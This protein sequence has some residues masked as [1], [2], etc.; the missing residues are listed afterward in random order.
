MSLEISSPGEIHSLLDYV[1][2]LFFNLED[3]KR[4]QESTR[5]FEF[6]EDSRPVDIVGW[7]R[8]GF[9]LKRGSKPRRFR[10]AVRKMAAPNLDEGIRSCRRLDKRYRACRLVQS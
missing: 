5:S 7:V 8:R 4:Q 10:A 1:H 3:L 2:D 6:P 9:P